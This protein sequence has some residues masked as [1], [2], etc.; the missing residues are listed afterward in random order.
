VSNIALELERYEKQ[1]KEIQDALESIKLL[2]IEDLE[3]RLKAIIAKENALKNLGPLIDQL[4]VLRNKNKIKQDDIK[5]S[6]NL[7]P[8][9]DGTL[10]G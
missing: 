4:D 9:E 2:E 1:I 7:S 10:D 8:L 3:E 5:G 6:K